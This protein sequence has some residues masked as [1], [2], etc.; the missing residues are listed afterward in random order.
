MAEMMRKLKSIPMKN[1]RQFLAKNNYKDVK[2][3]EY[4]LGKGEVDVNIDSINDSFTGTIKAKKQTLMNAETGPVLDDDIISFDYKNGQTEEVS[5]AKRRVDS[6]RGYI[7]L[8]NIIDEEDA[9]YK[10]KAVLNQ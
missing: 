9:V 4:Q 10:T 5:L 6:A 7:Y 2:C 8:H 3:S 1:V